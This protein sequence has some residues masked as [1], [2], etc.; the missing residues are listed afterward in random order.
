MRLSVQPVRN[1]VPCDFGFKVRRGIG[2][3][4]RLIAF[5]IMLPSFGEGEGVVGTDGE[6]LR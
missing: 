6:F 4:R 1:K 3:C 2:N 5:K